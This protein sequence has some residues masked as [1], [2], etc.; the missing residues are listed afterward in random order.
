MRRSRRFVSPPTDLFPP[1]KKTIV[2]TLQGL[3]VEIHPW[4]YMLGRDLPAWVTINGPKPLTFVVPKL[5]HR[6]AGKRLENG[7]LDWEWSVN[8]D[9][10]DCDHPWRGYIPLR[11]DW[12]K[13]GT[14][15]WLFEKQSTPSGLTTA[16]TPARLHIGKGRKKKIQ[17][18]Y[19][20]ID[21]LCLNVSRMYELDLPSRLHPPPVQWVNEEYPDKASICAKIWDARRSILELYGWISYQLLHDPHPWRDRFWKPGFISLLARLDFLSAPRRGVIIDPSSASDHQIIKLARDD[22]PIHYQWNPRGC[23]V[24]NPV[25]LT[26][27]AARFD[28]Y[29]FE[30]TRDYAAYRQAGGPYGIQSMDRSKLN[31]KERAALSADYAYGKNRLFQLPTLKEVSGNAKGKKRYFVYDAD[32]AEYIEVNKPSMDQLVCFENGETKCHQ[33]MM[34]FTFSDSPVR[35]L[36][37][38]NLDS[39]FIWLELEEPLT[40]SVFVQP[41]PTQPP[42]P[43][44]CLSDHDHDVPMRIVQSPPAQSSK[45]VAEV[46]PEAMV[47]DDQFLLDVDSLTDQGIDEDVTI[48][49]PG[50]PSYPP[51]CDHD[52]PI[53][54]DTDSPIDQENVIITQP[55]RPSH[56][57]GCDHDHPMDLTDPV[58]QPPQPL[59]LAVGQ[60]SHEV[61]LIDQPLVE[62]RSR[63]ADQDNEVHMEFTQLPSPTQPPHPAVEQPLDATIVDQSLHVEPPRPPIQDYESDSTISLGSEDMGN[64]FGEG[65]YS[66]GQLPL[67]TADI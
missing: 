2:Y 44:I 55:D 21:Y 53:L 10:E 17:L 57:P 20:A 31:G 42:H 38:S 34:V 26:D 61:A 41:Q 33:S 62:E 36:E 30:I 58:V 48:I 6:E 19:R 22:V 9:Y 52:H 40:E 7:T 54:L 25:I 4:I 27:V 29:D 12:V 46:L 66:L 5:C 50:R 63:S 67:Y 18:T 65:I 13:W 35:S 60:V 37:Q 32:D 49:Q 14:Q 23:V 11:D 8:A 51:G 15:G 45:P 64:L 24:H 59:Q 47:I 43:A 28:P 39:F 56:S 16:G 3:G 1:S